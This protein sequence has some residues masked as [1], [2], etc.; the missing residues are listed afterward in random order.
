[1]RKKFIIT[2][3]IL[4]GISGIVWALGY[5]PVAR[6]NDEYIFY[7]TYQERTGALMLFESKSRLVAGEKQLSDAEKNETKK[8][9]L[10]NL[11]T[12]QIFGQYIGEHAAL[13]G[14]TDLAHAVVESTLKDADPDVLPRATKELYG[15]SMEEFKQNVLYP[16]ALQN[17]LQKAIES[18]GA[19]FEEFTKT[20]LENA[21]VTLYLI[22]W[23]W[24]KGG[25]VGKQ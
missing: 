15:W 21:E 25:L 8:S 18:D 19:S 13:S 17:E 2:V 10:E 9:I 22:P 6:I 3:I 4:L 14:L 20:Q 11:I 1:M 16:Q 23:K 7:R 5:F 12:E 24:E